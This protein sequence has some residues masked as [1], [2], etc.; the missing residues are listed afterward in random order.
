MN[1]SPQAAAAVIGRGE[2]SVSFLPKDYRLQLPAL[3]TGDAAKLSVILHADLQGRP[4]RIEDFREPLNKAGVLPDVAGL[5]A[6]QMSHVWL[7]KLRTPEDKAKLLEAGHL[8]VK[9]RFC[10]VVDPSRRELRIKLYWVTFDIPVDT[11]RRAFEPFGVVKEIIRERWKIDGFVDVESTTLV[12]R[13][14]L[15]EGVALESLPHQL[16]FCGGKVLVVVPGRAPIC[17]RCRRTGH[18]RRTCRVPL[19]AQ[20]RAFGH[21]AAACVKTYA[22]ATGINT[23]EAPDDL[24]LM[25]QYEAE[26]AASATT[27][28]VP[29]T[30]SEAAL[31]D[32][33]SVE[34]T[35][36]PSASAPTVEKTPGV[37]EDVVHEKAE[38]PVGPG[39][40]ARTEEDDGKVMGG[41]NAKPRDG[42]NTRGSDDTKARGG[43]DTRAKGDDG[44]KAEDD[45]DAK[46]E[47]GA[48]D[49]D[50]DDDGSK[51][52]DVTAGKIKR[53]FDE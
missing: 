23:Q 52:M 24:N 48:N 9:G 51:H 5:G 30:P 11:V 18:I 22:R 4:Y 12:V 37:V 13:M 10:L 46:A 35:P 33:V 17:L 16:R 47:D 2:T 1:R 44:A 15:N 19:C 27:V 31:V 29:E 21:E 39:A 6:F 28:T 7:L 53:R 41:D 8:E 36:E 26:K 14:E 42:D 32:A 43:D 3:P 25:D 38:K 45:G 50:N 34:R 20:C 49:E 40:T